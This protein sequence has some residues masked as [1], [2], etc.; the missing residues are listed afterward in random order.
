MKLL[1]GGVNTRCTLFL[2][3]GF[4]PLGFPGKVFNEAANNA[5]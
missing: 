2:D 3:H 1:S 5:Y 4:V